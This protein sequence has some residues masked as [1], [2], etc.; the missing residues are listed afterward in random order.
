MTLTNK[1]RVFIEEYLKCWNAT[2]AAEAAG[3]KHARTHG[4]YLLTIL[5]IKEEIEIRIAE[6]TLDAD[7][8]LS[9]LGEHARA[10]WSEYLNESGN[11]EIKRLIED[12]KGHLIKGMKQTQWGRVIEF[13]DSQAALVHLGKHHGLFTDKLEHT[14]KIDLSKLTTEQLERIKKGDDV[15]SV[16]AITS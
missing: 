5:D 1:R 6:K 12:D 4:S 10:D 14:I 16:L 2:K 15:L 3:Y 9:R 13:Y 11:L 7:E 8:V